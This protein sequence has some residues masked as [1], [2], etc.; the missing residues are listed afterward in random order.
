[1]VSYSSRSYYNG[2]EDLLISVHG[3]GS[4]HDQVVGVRDAFDKI[5]KTINYLVNKKF[6]FR[7]NTVLTKYA[8]ESIL[9]L[10][11]FYIKCSP[12]IVNSEWSL[13]AS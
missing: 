11:N 3:Y 9:E 7:I 6:K 10:K 2:L 1:M 12:R 4:Y 13:M 5:T 8:C